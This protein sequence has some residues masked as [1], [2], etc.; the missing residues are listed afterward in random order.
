LLQQQSTP[1]KN[2]TIKNTKWVLR[3]RPEGLVKDSDF[4]LVTEI[5]PE[6][7]EDEILIENL[8]LKY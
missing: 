4:E 3:N 5:M 7:Q 2:M 8:F 6:I 1:E